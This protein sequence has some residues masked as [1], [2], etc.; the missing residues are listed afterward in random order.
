MTLA[1]MKLFLSEGEKL[2]EL[3]HKQLAARVA[4]TL[5]GAGDGG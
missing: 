2:T 1:Q 4:V 3:R 5:F